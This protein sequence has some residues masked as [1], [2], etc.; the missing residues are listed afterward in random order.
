MFIYKVCSKIVWEEIRSLTS[1]AGSPHDSRDGFIH[2]STEDQ[3][4][5]TLQ[6]HYAGQTDLMLLSIE[7]ESLGDALKWEPSRGGD[8]FPHLYGPLT[9][10]TI[11][12]ARDLKP[13]DWKIAGTHV[14]QAFQP[15]KSQNKSAWK[16]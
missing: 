10:T 8:L 14:R 9:I 1:W 4:P 7:A 5:G 16:G 3:L 2:F 13:E 15:D 6:K 12:Q 11:V